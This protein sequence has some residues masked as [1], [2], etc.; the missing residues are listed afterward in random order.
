MNNSCNRI[1]IWL[2]AAGLAALASIASGCRNQENGTGARK[3]TSMEM[4]YQVSPPWGKFRMSLTG[5]RQ[6]IESKSDTATTR[7]FNISDRD[8]LRMF[9]RAASWKEYGEVPF[10]S[11]SDAVIVALLRHRDGTDTICSNARPEFS[12]RFNGRSVR[13]SAL[14][15]LMVSTIAGR[16]SIWKRDVDSLFYNGH[17]NYMPERNWKREEFWGG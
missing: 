3:Y 9:S 1:S 4:I 11:S 7:R 5:Y 15:M 10:S 17:F 16:D 12:V 6:M 14:V 8:S 2:L 13:D